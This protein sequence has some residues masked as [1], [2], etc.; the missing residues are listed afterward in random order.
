MVKDYEWGIGSDEQDTAHIRHVYVT[1]FA[2]KNDD[3]AYGESPEHQAH[4]KLGTDY[5]E[6]LVLSITLFWNNHTQVPTHNICLPK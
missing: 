3:A 4:I 5:I 2:N 6:R 1:S